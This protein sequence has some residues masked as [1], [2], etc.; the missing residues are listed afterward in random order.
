MLKMA[1][2]KQL[3]YILKINEKH[4]EQNLWCTTGIRAPASRRALFFF[5]DQQ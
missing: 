5:E 4:Y 2:K 3:L 1:S